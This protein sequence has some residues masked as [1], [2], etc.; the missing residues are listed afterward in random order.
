[1]GSISYSLNKKEAPMSD[2]INDSLAK[3]FL[4]IYSMIANAMG[5]EDKVPAQIGEKLDSLY[6]SMVMFEE[7]IKGASF[8]KDSS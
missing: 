7:N 4:E 8:H 5:G 6:N 2:V 1:M 3:E